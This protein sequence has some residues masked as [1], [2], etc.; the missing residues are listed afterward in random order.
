MHYNAYL[1]SLTSCETCLLMGVVIPLSHSLHVSVKGIPGVRALAVI[2]VG[3]HH[4]VYKDGHS[5][6][7]IANGQCVNCGCVN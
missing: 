6:A 1:V 5:T 3:V 4:A 7:D 2:W